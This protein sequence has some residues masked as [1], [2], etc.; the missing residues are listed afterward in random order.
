[1]PP[2]AYATL[3]KVVA[4]KPGKFLR[5]FPG[6]AA[7]LRRPQLL[8][9][10]AKTAWICSTRPHPPRARRFFCRATSAP[11]GSAKIRVTR[12]AQDRRSPLTVKQTRARALPTP[13]D[14]STESA[15]TRA[16]MCV[17]ISGS[18]WR[19]TSAGS[20]RSRMPGTPA[21]LA[22]IACRARARRSAP[23]KCLTRWRPMCPW[24]LPGRHP[25]QARSHHALP[26]RLLSDCSWAA[27][28]YPQESFPKAVAF[29]LMNV[30]FYYP[31]ILR[32]TNIIDLGIDLGFPES[33][34][35]LNGISPVAQEAFS[36]NKTQ[37][38]RSGTAS[39]D[40]NEEWESST[41]QKQ[42]GQK[43]EAHSTQA[44]IFE[45]RSLFEQ[46][47]TLA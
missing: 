8:Q 23:Q 43:V 10:C 13:I 2:A 31:E 36:K 20:A 26:L 9:P 11:E 30:C 17:H 22:L 16:V 28:V 1:M 37:N 46:I 12:R 38:L 6:R 18:A 47:N 24:P 45:P 33:Q 14:Q 7:A 29:S 35:N 32:S 15:R 19:A 5:G 40:G 41:K 25:P 44:L 3:C 27:E 4:R 42:R 21:V 34:S 39:G